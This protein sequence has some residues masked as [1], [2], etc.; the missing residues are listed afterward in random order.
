MMTNSTE[1]YEHLLDYLVQTNQLQWATRYD[2]VA[3][4]VGYFGGVTE[5]YLE[6]I[7]ILFKNGMIK[8]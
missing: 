7:N 5:P 1:I 6:A 3:Y 2:C 8:A 4:C